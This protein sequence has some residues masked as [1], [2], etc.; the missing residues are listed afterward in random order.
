MAV[1][2]EIGGGV[3]KDRQDHVP[4]QAGLL[5]QGEEGE[6]GPGLGV[7]TAPFAQFGKCFVHIVRDLKQGHFLQFEIKNLGSDVHWEQA[8]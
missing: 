3:E 2:D 4:P 6:R 7:Q 5:E 8:L 1:Q